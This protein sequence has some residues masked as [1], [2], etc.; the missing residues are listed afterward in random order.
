[1]VLEHIT[2]VKLYTVRDE[3]QRKLILIQKKKAGEAGDPARARPSPP[4]ENKVRS[5]IKVREN[6]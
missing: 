1:M 3:I 5:S 6:R 2:R 4:R